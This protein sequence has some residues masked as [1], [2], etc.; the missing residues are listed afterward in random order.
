[1]SEND[2]KLVIVNPE[3]WAKHVKAANNEPYL[4][5]ADIFHCA[6]LW[7]QRMQEYVDSNVKATIA[8]AAEKTQQGVL[9]QFHIDSTHIEYFRVLTILRNCWRWGPDLQLWHSQR[10][11]V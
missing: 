3:L 7:A 2:L 8:K 1:M 9:E 5:D 10:Y 6:E 11:G 4:R